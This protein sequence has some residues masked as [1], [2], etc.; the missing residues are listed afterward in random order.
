MFKNIY[1]QDNAANNQAIYESL[2][3]SEL[4]RQDFY[5]WFKSKLNYTETKT[6]EQ[7][8]AEYTEFIYD[9][10][11]RLQYSSAFSIELHND[12]DHKNVYELVAWNIIKWF[13]NIWLCSFSWTVEETQSE[14]YQ[15]GDTIKFDILKD[16]K[17]NK[18]WDITL[19]N[20]DKE[21]QKVK[22]NIN[23]FDSEYDSNMIG[24]YYR[25]RWLEV[26]IKCCEV[27]YIQNTA[28]TKLNSGIKETKSESVNWISVSYAD[29]EQ[30]NAIKAIL[31][32]FTTVEDLINDY[33]NQLLELNKKYINEANNEMYGISHRFVVL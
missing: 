20:E 6:E 23:K 4:D 29:N 25:N 24:K 33:V 10:I 8:R 9:I 28:I 32:D 17:V 31:W 13:K 1:I 12:T 19:L 18:N 14:D 7:I 3:S 11:W 15:I 26:F 5:T 21:I 27:K 2:K 16:F 30:S 22:I